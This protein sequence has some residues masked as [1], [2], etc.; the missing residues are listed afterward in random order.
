MF[1]LSK[2]LNSLPPYLFLEIDRA[3]R[4]AKQMG[5]D[6]ID[7]GIGDPDQPTPDFIIKA[8]GHAVRDKRTHS[9]PLDAGDSRFREAVA[10]WY[11]KRFG[12]N[13]NSQTEILPL[14]GSKEGITH[15]PLA[16]INPGDRVLIPEPGYPAYRSGVLLAGGKPVTLPLY[17]RDGFLPVWSRMSKKDLRRAKMVYLNYPN[18]P[19]SAVANTPFFNETVQFAKKNDVMIC[20]DNAYSEIYSR[21]NLPSSFLQARGAK[22]VGI[23]FHSLSK[24][25]N[26]TGW[27]IGFACGNAKMIQGLAKVKSNL[28]SGVF[29]AIQLTAAKALKQTPAFIKKM[30]QMYVQRRNILTH[31][32]ESM[33]WKVFPS[34]STFF[35]WTHLPAPWTKSLDFSKA[36]LNK[37]GIVVTPGVGFGQSGEGFVRFSLTI[38]SSRIK[39]AIKRMRDL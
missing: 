19:T 28:D 2:R 21:P 38:N 25:F 12:V 36:L 15:L 16:F 32:L 29:T 10:Q 4:K 23:E 35:V 31:G 17:E 3:K 33:G 8:L 37:S 39:E 1:K 9:Y 13:L 11:R 7:F 14:I 24:T 34:K 22:D 30:N 27:R 20:H 5:M 6:V 26:M 18:N